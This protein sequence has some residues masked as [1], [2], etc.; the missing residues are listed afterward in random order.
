[1]HETG[2]DASTYGGLAVAAQTFLQQSSDLRVTER[3]MAKA[4]L[5]AKRLLALLLLLCLR[6]NLN[7]VS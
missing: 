2:A 5:Q 6:K 3:N 1:M 4:G 7:T